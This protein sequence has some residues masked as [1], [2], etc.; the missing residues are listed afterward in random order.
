VR[1]SQNGWPA[2]EDRAE[3]G[4]ATFVVPGFSQVKLPLQRDCAPLLVEMARW[5]FVNIEPPVIPGCWGFAFRAIRGQ[6]SGYS[7]HASGTG[8]DL[9]APLHVLGAYGTVPRAKRAAISAKARSL[10]LRWGGDYSGRK[11][12]MHF[13]VVESREQVRARVRALQAPPKQTTTKEDDMSAQAEQQIRELHEWY[14]KGVQGRFTR[15]ELAGYLTQAYVNTN[16]LLVLQRQT[17]A[18]VTSNP[19]ITPE[20]LEAMLARVTPTAEQIAAAVA[21]IVGDDDEEE[22]AQV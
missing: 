12:E 9:N 1:S 8:M 6:T 19:D 4:V 20:A 21:A 15:G 22:G 13:E 7:N 10:G 2:S 14:R 17:L 16:Q 5:W 11:D 18:V 3:I